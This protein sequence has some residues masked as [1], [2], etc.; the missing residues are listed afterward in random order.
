[1]YLLCTIRRHHFSYSQ[2]NAANSAYVHNSLV[3]GI[4]GNDAYGLH[5]GT[6]FRDFFWCDKIPDP[7]RGQQKIMQ[8][9]RP[10]QLEQFTVLGRLCFH[11]WHPSKA[12]APRCR[13]DL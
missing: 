5:I 11:T 1:M 8:Q 2:S 12:S 13:D 10:L 7:Q 3:L 6:L 4:T 9:S